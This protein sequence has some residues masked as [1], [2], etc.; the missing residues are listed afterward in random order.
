MRAEEIV[1]VIDSPAVFAFLSACILRKARAQKSDGS[2]GKSWPRNDL[3]TDPSAPMTMHYACGPGPNGVLFFFGG[4]LL[5][6]RL[7]SGAVWSRSGR[8]RRR[9]WGPG[10]DELSYGTCSHIKYD[11]P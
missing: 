5:E 6:Q 3:A 7:W 2:Q 9:L 10:T 4:I 8:G 11:P 1:C